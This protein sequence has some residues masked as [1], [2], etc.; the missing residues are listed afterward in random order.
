METINK[1]MIALSVI[2]GGFSAKAAEP[3]EKQPNFVIFITDQQQNSKLSWYG[4]P[5]LYTPTMDKIAESGYSFMNAYCAFPLSIPQ[6]FSLFT[7]M[8][9]SSVNLRFNPSKTDRSLVNMDAIEQM[10]PYML[11]NILHFLWRKGTSRI[12]R[13]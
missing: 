10:Q 4:E 11:A 2:S 8:Y 9:P 3:Q 12:K 6:R 5:G 13:N 1:T 7:G